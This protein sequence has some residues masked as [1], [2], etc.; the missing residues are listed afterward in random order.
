[1]GF[2]CRDQLLFSKQI[3]LMSLFCDFQPRLLD[4]RV[5]GLVIQTLFECLNQLDAI[6]QREMQG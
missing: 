2:F 4:A 6:F 1:M 3:V 5:D